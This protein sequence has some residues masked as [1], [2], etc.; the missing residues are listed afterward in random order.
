V[1]LVVVDVS[2]ISI[3]LILPVIPPLLS[4]RRGGIIALVKPQFEVGRGKVGKGG[5]VRSQ[6]LRLE[7]VFGIGSFAMNEGL[8]VIGVTS[9][10]ITGAEGNREYFI[11]LSVEPGGLTQ[12]SWRRIIELTHEEEE[13]TRF[14]IIKR[15][16]AMASESS[17]PIACSGN[18]TFMAPVSRQ[19]RWRIFRESG[20]GLDRDIA[21]RQA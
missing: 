16:P 14:G 1:D 18:G 13:R 19:P 7:A 12:G 4:P 20:R 8:G 11:H 17:A 3:R 2:F 10:P 5:I 15:Q 9:S 6:Q 21:P